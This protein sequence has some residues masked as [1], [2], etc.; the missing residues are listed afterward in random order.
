MRSD[1]KRKKMNVKD[2]LQTIVTLLDG[3]NEENDDKYQ[4][5]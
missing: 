3:G 4:P 1:E 2:I 5:E